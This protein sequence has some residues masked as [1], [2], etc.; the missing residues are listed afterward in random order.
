VS[1]YVDTSALFALLDADDQQHAR[2]KAWFEAWAQ[3]GSEVLV[4]H[5]YAVVE[6]AALVQR[7]L[8]RAATRSLFEDLLPALRVEYINE[9]L[10]KLAEGVH[11]AAPTG[12]SFVDCVSFQF[13]RLGGVREAFAFDRHFAQQGF[14]AV[15][16]SEADVQP[17]GGSSKTT[18]ASQASEA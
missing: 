14:N 7:R 11:L 12:P 16:E 8:G 18:E 15:P 2:A 13:M 3:S 4:T 5:N 6:T 10:H 17:V 1:T 9:H